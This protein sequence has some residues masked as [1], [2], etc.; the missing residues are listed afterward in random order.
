[1]KHYV[2]KE[3]YEMVEKV[4]SVRNATDPA[5]IAGTGGHPRLYTVLAG[6]FDRIDEA[7]E[8]CAEI[9]AA[10]YRDAGLEDPLDYSLPT[11]DMLHEYRRS[12]LAS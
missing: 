4:I 10:G 5:D 6:P 2:V 1:M 7:R 9:I 12:L 8:N 3:Q 11:A